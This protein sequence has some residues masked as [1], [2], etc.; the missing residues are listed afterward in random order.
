[1]AKQEGV[2][3][4]A[5][6]FCY[7][8]MWRIVVDL[9]LDVAGRWNGSE[10]AINPA[11]AGFD[12]YTVLHEI[13][14]SMVGYLC[15]REHCEYAAHGVA[16]AFGVMAGCDVSDWGSRIAAYSGFSECPKKGPS[17]VVAQVETDIA[18]ERGYKEG[19]S[20]TAKEIKGDMRD[21][22]NVRYVLDGNGDL[23]KGPLSPDNTL[24]WARFEGVSEVDGSGIWVLRRSECP[25]RFMETQ[26]VEAAICRKVNDLRK[27][28]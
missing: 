5:A 18:Y 7:P 26:Q 28:G 12:A 21:W 8:P 17:M 22:A 20:N 6:P 2:T 4:S 1:M 14:H 9:S 19:A 25:E 16:V 11:H 13:G 24:H 3:A 27:C 15:C 10:V 23:W